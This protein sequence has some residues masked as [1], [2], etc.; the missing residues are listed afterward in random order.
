MM[1]DFRSAADRGNWIRGYL[2]TPGVMP[3]SGEKF[4]PSDDRLKELEERG[5]RA[6]AALRD[7]GYDVAGDLSV[8]E[9]AEVHDRRHPGDVTDA[10]QL[11]VAVQ[12]IAALMTR[13][14]ELRRE[15][16]ASAKRQELEKSRVSVS[17]FVTGL[18]SRIRKDD[19]S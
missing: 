5:H 11:D 15:Q 18:I 4:R 14:R 6:V 13:V 7:G 1:E 12:V 2:A 17:R 19:T 9:P 3:A 10:E 16:R 8:L